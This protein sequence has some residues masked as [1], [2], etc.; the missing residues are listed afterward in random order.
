[1]EARR[2]A[3]VI[4]QLTAGGAEGQVAVLCRGLR[5]NGR[6]APIVYCLSERTEPW[7]PEIEA[8]GVPLRVIGGGRPQ[9]LWRLR[10]ALAADGVALVHAWL[11]I[12]NAY[13]W[14]A[15][16]GTGRPLLTSAR[17]CK[18][19][20]RWLDR[21]NRRA[22]AASA[23][24][25]A[26]SRQVARYIEQTYGAPGGRIE[27]VYNAIDTTRFH[28][29]SEAHG[30]APCVVMVGRLVPQK[31]PLLF[32]EAAAAVHRKLP[33]V[34]FLLVGDGSLRAA[35]EAAVDANGL[36]DCCTVAG[37]RRDVPELLRQADLFWLTSEWEGLPNAVLEA[38]ATGLPAVVTDVG[39]AGEIVRPDRDGYLIRPGDRDALVARSLGLLGDGERRRRCGEAARARAEE[40]SAP[41]MVAA[42]ERL[43]TQVLSGRQ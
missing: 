35:V 17:N 12:A 16:A 21:L 41:Q 34:R 25:V 40:F 29:P 37:E 43:Y 2:I 24:I 42:M 15:N 19:Q 14:A 27:V 8:L 26:N 10:R 31:N 13:A 39:G 11:F 9:R 6:F 20:G 32:V 5:D 23:A 4:G 22:F 7:G 1:M 28:P 30:G 33:G 3:L 18:R 38:M 36:R